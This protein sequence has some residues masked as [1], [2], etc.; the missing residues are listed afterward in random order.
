M[1]IEILF[2]AQL[3]DSFG[4]QC[5]SMRLTPGD[6]VE[7][8][9]EQLAA[10]PEWRTV[11]ALPLTFAVNEEV[12]GRSHPLKDGDRLAVLTPVSGG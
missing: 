9:V 3:R 7:A 11:Q 2:F 6:T 8:A 12:V 5:A 10:K 4:T 1:N